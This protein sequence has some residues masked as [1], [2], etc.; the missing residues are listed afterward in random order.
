MTSGADTRVIVDGDTCSITI[1]PA[2][3]PVEVL[4]A[5]AALPDGVGFAEAFGD[6]DV[7]LVFRPAGE[8]TSSWEA[9]GTTSKPG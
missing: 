9:D 5:W 3:R 6:V 4:R 1:R 8:L 7:T 2:D